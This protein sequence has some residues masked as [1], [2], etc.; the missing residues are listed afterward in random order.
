MI[1]K[2]NRAFQ[3]FE[4]VLVLLTVVTHWLIF[5]FILINSFKTKTEASQ[6]SLAFP[7]EWNIAENYAYIFQYGKG[8]F[9]RHLKTA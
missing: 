9:S 3:M 4:V 7:K 6:L 5:Y 2:K 1:K 8:A